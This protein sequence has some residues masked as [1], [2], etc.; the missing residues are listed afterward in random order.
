MKRIVAG[1]LIVCGILCLSVTPSTPNRILYLLQA[2]HVEDAFNLY[3][4]FT[5]HH[6]KHDAELLQQ[7]GLML[8]NEGARS[9]D[10]ETQLLTLFGAGISLNEKTLY[11]LEEGLRSPQPQLQLVALSFL[12][13]FN[14]DE[15]DLALNRALSSNFALIRLEAVFQLIK[16]KAPHAVS[17]AESLMSKLP[18]E[19]APLFPQMFAH[20]GT[21]EAMRILRKMLAHSSQDVRVEAVLAAAKNRRD[22]ML[23]SIRSLATHHALPQQEACAFAFGAL[24]DESAVPK[25]QQLTESRSPHV[26]LSALQALN[27]LGRSEVRAEIVKMANAENI[28]AIVLLGEMEG[29]EESLVALMQH[30]NQQ[31]KVNAVLALLKRKDP[32]CLPLLCELLIR[33][34]RDLALSKVGSPGGVFTAYKLIPSAQ[35]NLGDDPASLEQSLSL[36]EE[37]IKAAVELPEAE[38]FRFMNTLLSVQQNNL[39]PAIVGSLEALRT[40]VAVEVLKKLQQKAG[41]PLIRNYCNLALYRLKEEGTYS[42]NLRK[43]VA[44]QHQGELIQFRPLIGNEGSLEISEYQLTPQETS[45]LLVESFEALTQQQ[46]EAGITTL[47][48]AIQYGNAKNKYALTGLLMRASQ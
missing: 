27:S 29:S 42:D 36:R 20:A 14:N 22:D 37:A 43:W 9:A 11:I 44:Q 33:D 47:L 6:Q 19:A 41:A 16:R 4:E 10:P 2:G 5:A 23:P 31:I 38:F 8:L 30:P 46:D 7:I 35:Q 17:H 28:F 3:R 45:R 25:L 1:V 21:P 15:A 13:K 40:P 12:A 34:S 32:R 48:D 26:K 18:V 39:V 24:K